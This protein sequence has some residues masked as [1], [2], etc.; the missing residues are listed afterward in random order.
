MQQCMLLTNTARVT[1]SASRGSSVNRE[2]DAAERARPQGRPCRLKVAEKAVCIAKEGRPKPGISDP[3][4][5]DTVWKSKVMITRLYPA[6]RVSSV[7]KKGSPNSRATCSAASLHQPST[8]ALVM[9]DAH[10]QM[11]ICIKHQAHGHAKSHI[12]EQLQVDPQAASELGRHL[13]HNFVDRM[14]ALCDAGH[15]DSQHGIVVLLH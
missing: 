13:V 11:S 6:F 12:Q 14:R 1:G 10:L 15:E 3:G 4:H 2:G 5:A 7:S 8:P 9:R